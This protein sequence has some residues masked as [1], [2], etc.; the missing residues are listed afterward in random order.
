MPIFWT[1]VLSE[2]KSPGL[3][4]ALPDDKGKTMAKNDQV[5][6]TRYSMIKKRQWQRITS[7]SLKSWLARTEEYVK[8]SLGEKKCILQHSYKLIVFDDNI[9]FT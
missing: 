6:D 9:D 4:Q 7:S 8:A 3:R 1:I 2:L 5:S